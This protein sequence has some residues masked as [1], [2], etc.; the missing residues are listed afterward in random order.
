MRQ[1]RPGGL[2]GDVNVTAHRWLPLSSHAAALACP[3]LLLTYCN[4]I[5][6]T[7]Q[8]QDN[9]AG[10]VGGTGICCWPP[11]PGPPPA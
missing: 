5:T 2:V 11:P 10:G 1:P 4:S 8:V 7:S 9:A 6:L 3:C